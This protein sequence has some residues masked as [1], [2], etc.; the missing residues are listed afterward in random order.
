MNGLGLR[1]TRTIAIVQARM[2]S[3]RL[4]GKVMADL[5]GRPML[6]RVVERTSKARTLDDV[7]VA[8][9][10]QTEDDVIVK[11]CLEYKY[12]FFRGSREDVLDRYYR[13]ASISGAGVVVRIT[14]DCPLIE[15]DIID[16]VV[17]K[18]RN[19]S[20]ADY[21]SNTLKRTF[22][23]GLDVEVF[24]FNALRVAW[25]EDKNPAWREHV[26]QYIKR[27]PDVF[28]VHNVA[29]DVDYSHMRWTVDTSEDLEFVR[30]IYNYFRNDTF[31]WTEVLEL[32]KNHP[33]W[34]EINRHVR[35][36]SV[37]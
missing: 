2:G 22:P 24:S 19:Y 16:M 30:R 34:L 7:V 13:A 37:G 5:S 36:K 27:N 10:R 8:T 12:S 3:T 11:M 21:V 29:G 14:S 17:D 33:D 18:F 4:P 15:P 1:D 35:Q 28:S 25:K 31:H 6:V 20:G 26:T 9:T 23:R 32:L